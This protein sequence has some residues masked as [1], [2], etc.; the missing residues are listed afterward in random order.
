LPDVVG[1]TVVFT[2]PTGLI[3][4]EPSLVVKGTATDPEPDA[5]GVSQILIRVNAELV[6]R[7]AQGTTNW[8]APIQLQIGAN[9]IQAAAV[10]G[11]GNQGP[12]RQISVTYMPQ[13]P[14]NDHFVNAIELTNTTGSVTWSSLRATK[15][16]GEPLHAGNEGGSSIWGRWT[17]P[18]DG[19]IALNTAGSAF[20]TLLGV[21]IGDRVNALTNVAFS[22]DDA[23][24]GATSSL[25][26]LAVHTGVTYHIA[27]DGYAGAQGQ[28][29]LAYN[30]R[31]GAL[32]HV[33]VETEGSGTVSPGTG[34]Y[35]SAV[36]LT[37]TA[38]A[39]PGFLFTGWSGDVESGVNPLTIVPDQDLNITAT[40]ERRAF[41][42]DFETGGFNPALNYNFNPLESV[43]MWQV[44]GEEAAM[45][46][47]SA[48]AG[49][50][51]HGQ[52]SILRLT[53]V[54]DAGVGSFSYKVS[55][56]A[57][58][59]GLE[60]YLNGLRLQKWSGEVAWQTYEF[61][62]P[63]GTNTFEW[64]YVKDITLNA[65][66]DTAFIDNLLLPLATAEQGAPQLKLS[67][68]SREPQLELRGLPDRAYYLQ[69]S[70]DLK[71]WQTISTNIAVNGVVRIDDPTIGQGAG[72]YYRA[73]KP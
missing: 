33:V 57:S 62:V 41:T 40:F 12:T 10:D 64:R 69:A 5:S 56:E 48:R 9:T 19:A 38:T 26:S 27:V 53:E 49:A 42:D 66:L 37:L 36:P 7:S 21:Y 32:F 73:V 58:W 15:E 61:S 71:D 70:P 50:I 22:D 72:R 14:V 11:A 13:D 24:T 1:P 6:G 18:A 3:T 28:V 65:G 43:A 44:Q 51:A 16:S 67:Y 63:A 35:P 52:K 31:T 20:D 55:S 25:I 4:T 39:E 46:E 47:Y 23:T 17:A 54:L 34:D 2:T 8:M 45:G 30:F 68:V 60:F 59:D 29:R